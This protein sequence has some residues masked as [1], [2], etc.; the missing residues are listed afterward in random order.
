MAT[1]AFILGFY[2]PAKARAA[3]EAAEAAAPLQPNAFIK[4]DADNTI[5]FLMGLAEMGQG[6]YTAMAM[7][8]ADELDAD[9][10]AVHFKAADVAP[11][12]NSVFG[13]FMLTAGSTSISTKHLE[14]RKIGAA[15]NTMLKTAAAHRWNTDISN[16]KTS[17]AHVIN[18]QSGEKFTYGE[19]VSDINTM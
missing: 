5:T 7:S 4:I 2:L 9:W 8:I 6:T 11:I 13:P 1:G 3:E 19:L 12:Y 18:V 14:M 10:E 15:V 16:V 17:K